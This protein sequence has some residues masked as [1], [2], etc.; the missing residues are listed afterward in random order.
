MIRRTLNSIRAHR[1]IWAA[2]VTVC[3]PL[4]DAFLFA[5]DA[6]PAES[7]AEATTEAAA[8]TP[9]ADPSAAEATEGEAEKAADESKAAAEKSAEPEKPEEPEV[10]IPFSSLPYS[11]RASIAFEGRSLVRESKR[12]QIV[13]DIHR[14]LARMYG[15]LWNVV[16]DQNDWMVPADHRHLERLQ[17]GHVVERYPEEEFHK[18]F[19]VTV[20]RDG[21]RFLISCR[22]YDSRIHELTPVRSEVTED[23]RS[24]GNT[25]ARLMRDTFRPNL[26]FVRSFPG[27]SYGGP[28]RDVENAGDDDAGDYPDAP[29]ASDGRYDF[30]VMMEMQVQGGEI[31]PPDSS[32]T[33]VIPGDVLRPFVRQMER[34]QPKKLKKLQPLQLTYLRVIDIDKEETRGL[35]TT[36][37]ITHLRAQL[38]GAKGRRTQHIAVRQ[39]PGAPRSRVR[40]VLKGSEDK[41]LISHRL[42]LAYQLNWK[43]PEDGPQTQLVSDRNGEV[44]IEY[45]ENHPTFWIRVYSGT[46]LL[47]RVPY[48]PGLIPFDTIQLPDDSIRLAVEGEIQLLSDELVDAIA[49]REVTIARSKKAAAAGDVSQVEELF[50]KYDTIPAKQYFLEQASNIR[51]T[52]EK[53]SRA[54]RLRSTLSDRMCKNFTGTIETFFTDEKRAAR[55]LEIQQIRALAQ[56]NAADK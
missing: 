43:S 24:I 6:P 23:E 55:Q 39:R 34:R 14:A 9:P 52:A 51:V 46:S 36:V 44:T 48:A 10:E 8:A 15:R 7:K 35:A 37:F 45:R 21:T 53:E 5:Q 13:I 47:A 42:A 22:E 18:A 27:N 25:A 11:V 28:S 17:L 40:L 19:L 49:L 3:L 12:Q 33:Q 38:F 32:A 16:C 1:V 20:E 2:L 29:P 30:A 54:R 31:I 50:A 26:L 4:P 41:P 56:Q